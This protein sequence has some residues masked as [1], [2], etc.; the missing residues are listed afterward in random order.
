M[1]TTTNLSNN[2]FPRS[3]VRTFAQC[4]QDYNLGWLQSAEALWEIKE[5]RLFVSEYQNFASCVQEEFSLTKRRANQLIAGYLLAKEQYKAGTNCSQFGESHY[6][7][8]GQLKTKQCT[9]PEK[10]DTENW[11]TNTV[12]GFDQNAALRSRSQAA[13]NGLLPTLRVGP[14]HLLRLLS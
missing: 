13:I 6:R 8:L 2:S 14:F 5:R 7:E 3:G 11:L 4:K 1:G 10:T 12:C 9:S